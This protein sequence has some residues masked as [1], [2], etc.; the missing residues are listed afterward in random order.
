MSNYSK[1]IEK[2]K[3]VKE[4][5]KVRKEKLASFFFDVAKLIIA[6]IVIGGIT[7]MY[8]NDYLNVNYLVV[9]FGTIAAVFFAWIGNK[10]L[11]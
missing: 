5:D 7:P 6:G 8:N 1:N 10:I 9:I 2:Q 3:E 11:K 4:K